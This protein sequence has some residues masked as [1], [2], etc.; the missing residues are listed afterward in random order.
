MPGADSGRSPTAWFVRRAGLA[1]CATIA[2]A[3]GLSLAAFFPG[4]YL[5]AFAGLTLALGGI[6]AGHVVS[7]LRPLS[8]TGLAVT[9]ASVVLMGLL[10]G[11]LLGTLRVSSL[12]DGE[13]SS[14]MGETVQAQ[15]VVTGPVRANAG[16]QSATAVVQTISGVAGRT[17]GPRG[18]AGAGEKLLLEV[19]PTDKKASVDTAAT[20]ADGGAARPLTQGALLSVRGVLRAPDGPSPS[21]FDQAKQLLHQGIRVVLLVEGPGGLSFRGQRGGV[22]GWFD[23]LRASAKEHLSLGPDPRVNEVLQGVVMGDTAGIDQGWMDAFRRSG[24]A[25]MLSVSG[26]HVASLAA[27]IIALAGFARLSRKAG[28]VLAAAAAVLMVP[29]VGSSPPILRSAVMIVVVLGGRLVGR[30]RD[31]WQGLA[32]AALIVLMLNPFAIFDV[33]FQLSFCAFIGMIALV[34]PVERLLHGLPDSVRANLAVSLAAT[35]GTAPVSLVV[36]GRTSL[37]SPLANLLVVPTLAGVTGLGMASVLLG[38]VWRGFSVAF[39]TLASLPMSWTILVS[40]LCARVPVLAAG[41]MGRVL[42]ALAAGAL[43]L[44]AALAL[45]GRAVGPPLGLRLPAFGRSVS[46]LR[47][48]RPRDRRQGGLLGVTLVLVALVL[49]AACYPVA[50]AGL[51]AA[52]LSAGTRGWPTQVEVRVLDVGQGT[53]VLVRTPEHRAA[54]FDAGPAGCR[55]AGQLRSLGVKRLDLVVVS[56]PHADHF[57][58]LLE[59]IDSLEVGTFVDRTEVVG[60]DTPAPGTAGAQAASVGS[61]GSGEAGQYLE[62]RRRLSAGGSRLLRASLGSSLTVDGVYIAFFG[63]ARSLVLLGGGDPWGEGRDPPSGDEM[64]GGSL[65]ALLGIGEARVLLPGDAEADVLD[66]Y[67]LPSFSAIVVPHHGSRGAVSQRLLARQ[68]GKLAL[69]SVGKNNTFGHPNRDT[70]AM[71]SAAGDTIVRTD[72]CGWVS[73]R[74]NDAEMTISTERNRAP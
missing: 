60:P 63:P 45:S 20:P 7:R 55:L 10:A 9:L 4:R 12:L 53:A 40:T 8:N 67:R 30:R 6:L 21:G 16:W 56:H 17:E 36:F 64:N 73:L 44:P 39:D 31:Q 13:L 11:L 48:R 32:F 47:A 51:R 26:L 41:D 54:L 61:A 43:V 46:W 18:G 57:A 69:I 74:L 66:T 38:F 49:G 33:G 35:L 29:F 62:L 68:Q 71:L 23:H 22:S 58:G 25:H 28:F 34:G 1:R 72:E 37:I 65:V 70:V 14:R 42:L 24:T 27:I 59:A 19:A 3:A 5:V 52:E 2:A 50:A 15:I